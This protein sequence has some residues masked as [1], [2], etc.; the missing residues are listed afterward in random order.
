MRSVGPPTSK[1]L[2][3]ARDEFAALLRGSPSRPNFKNYSRVV[4]IFFLVHFLSGWNL[5]TSIPWED[6]AGVNPILFSILGLLTLSAHSA[7]SN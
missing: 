3:A 2:Q 6:L 7:L 1:E 5:L 4:L